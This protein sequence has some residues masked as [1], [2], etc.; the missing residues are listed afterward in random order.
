MIYN[1]EHLKKEESDYQGK[2]PNLDHLQK[3]H[4]AIN[5]LPEKCKQI[6][7]HC[8]VSGYTYT[9]TAEELGISINTVR[10]QMFRAF[11]QLRSKLKSPHLFYLLLLLK[12]KA[13][14]SVH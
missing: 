7:M 8:C 12:P 6:F 1:I 10:T 4:S 14:F 3:I 9:E 13:T 5:E 11:K 2:E